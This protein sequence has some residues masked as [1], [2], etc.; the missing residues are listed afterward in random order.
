MKIIA[1]THTHTIASGHAFSTITENVRAARER[2]LRFLCMTDHAPRLLGAPTVV[3]FGG[4]TGTV[5]LEIENV[6]ILRGVEVN[7]LDSAGHLD[8]TEKELERLEWVIASMHNIVYTPED[9]AAHT[10]AWLAVAE[11]PNVDVMGHLGDGQYPFEHEEVIRACAKN[12][13][14]VEINNHSFNV[15]RG[16]AE[17]CRDI[18]KLCMKHGVPVVV[19]TDAHYLDAIGRFEKSLA[20]L[21][22]IGFPEE[23]ILNAD[24]ARFAKVVAEKT[25]RTF[26]E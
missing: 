6:Y 20:M 23:L 17:N 9:V 25:G 13:K 19:S 12:G 3:Y 21:E 15:R 16:S 2:G 5:P 26:T 10:R 18:A 4:I 22:E 11:N 8:L 24:F 7:V 1:D 14:I